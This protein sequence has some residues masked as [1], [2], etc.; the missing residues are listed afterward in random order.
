MGRPRLEPRLYLD[1]QRRAWVIRDGK[2]YIRTGRNEGDREEAELDLNAYLRNGFAL[3]DGEC[4]YFIVGN[5]RLKIGRARDVNERLNNLQ[6]YC[7][8]KLRL[9][10][11]QPGGSDV[12][13]AFHRRFAEYRTYGEWFEIRGELEAFLRE[14]VA[15]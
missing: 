5:N 12:E 3:G 13:S 4:V 6:R 11:S 2:K 15:L 9:L 1:P 7:P 14:R 8:I 10:W